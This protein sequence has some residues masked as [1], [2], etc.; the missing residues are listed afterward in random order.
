MHRI[1]WGEGLPALCCFAT[2]ITLPAWNLLLGDSIAGLLVLTF[3]VLT[4][5]F[6]LALGIHGAAVTG[7]LHIRR[8]SY[9]AIGLNLLAWIPLGMSL[10]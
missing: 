4:Q 10:S 5:A 3:A 7:L 9:L 1:R 8:L 6:G 2:A